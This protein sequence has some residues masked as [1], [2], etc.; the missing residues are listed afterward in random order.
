M[1]VL[2]VPVVLSELGW[3]AQGIVDTIMVGK[4]GPAAI[5]AVSLG[6][7]VYYTPSLF[8]IGLLLGL[9]TLVAQAFGRRDHDEC[10]RWLAQ[11]VYLAFIVTPPIMLLLAAASF[12]FARFGIT[13]AVAAPASTYLRLLNW[14]TLPLLL[15]G[16]TR[17]YLQGVGQVRVITVTYVLAN[18]LN[19]AGNWILIYGK[20]GFPAL[21]VNGSAISTCIARVAMAAALLGFAWR[22]ER[23]RGH[24]LFRHWAGPSLQR[25]RQLVQLGAPAA[26]QILLE[27]GAWNLATFSA[28]YLTPVALATHSIALNYASLTYM[29]PLGVSAAAAVSVGHAVGAGEPH[30]ARR[31]GW[32]ALGLGTSFMLL[33]AVVFLVAPRPL[34]A[35]YTSDPRVLAVGPSLLWI[36]AAFQ[37]FDGVQTVCTGALRGLG[38]T[39]MPMFAN[40]IGYWVLGLPLGLALCFVLHW[41]I[42]GLWIGLTLALVF[43]SLALLRRWRRDSARLLLTP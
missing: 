19:W 40:L 23:Q 22:Y 2:A 41:G 37:I 5:G 15:Y 38:E 16:G 29:V 6:N 1:I 10:H 4:L 30:R 42:Y 31:A 24:P 12:G 43:I 28:G 32:L 33:A 14:G 18:L 26:G 8:G 20:L 35:L 21:G 9:D 39:R 27:V 25:L 13:P 3:M 34:I 11:G 17:R 36:A 7:A